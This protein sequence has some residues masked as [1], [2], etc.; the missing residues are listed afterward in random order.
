VRLERP[1]AQ[2]L[3]I[4][5]AS[6]DL[7]RRKIL[8]A[9]YN[10]FVDDCLPERFAVV[11]YAR[12]GWDDD[13]FRKHARGSVEEFSRRELNEVKWKE[14]GDLLHY[15]AGSFDEVDSFGPL[16]RRLAEFDRAHGTGGK[17]LYYCATPPS[18]FPLIVERLAE[19]GSQE[20]A[21]IVIE[22]PFGR[23]LESAKELTAV[24]HEVFDESRVFRIDHYLGKET[25]QNLVV[26]RFANS[27]F[28]RAWNREA[29]DHVQITVAESIGVGTRGSYY[30]E[31]GA[32]RDIVQN[33]L[34]QVLSFL[35][36]EPPRSLEPEAIRD[37]TV[38]LLSAVRPLEPEE[39]VRGQYAAGVIDGEQVP[40]YREEESVAAGSDVETYA[41]ARVWID[42]WRWSD[43][44]IFM[45]TGKRLA[46]QA[47]EI[48]V[49][50]RRPP[51]YLFDGVGLPSPPSDHLVIRIAPTEGISFDFQAKKE[52]VGFEPETEQMDFSYGDPSSTPDAYERLLHDAMI[53][54][55][56]LFTRR[57]GVE[58]AW[59][60]VGPVLDQP[61]PVH[62]YPAGSWG[63][64]EAE[65][66]IAP[67]EWHAGGSEE[68]EESASAAGGTMSSK[69]RA[70]QP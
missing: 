51:A 61:G 40:G 2:L 27:V 38:K 19:C 21:T 34:L 58:R 44:P 43:V 39:V 67:H 28:E 66:L 65:D 46:W 31:S 24:I 20:K 18:A 33:H 14:F 68:E 57:D 10:L 16:D 63:P 47:T 1:P 35:A 6:G 50:F 37:E 4:F 45:R 23:D 62:L 32:I 12:S 70:R 60:L 30:E 9:L 59:E 64:R 17:R 25:V 26:F 11:G 42:N 22:K 41:A 49:V 3:V 36:M 8:P 5:G 29:I 69:V 7:T 56:T 52:G 54:D 55:R 13:T 53:G 48:A 15:V